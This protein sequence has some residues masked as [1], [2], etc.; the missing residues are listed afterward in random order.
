MSGRLTGSELAAAYLSARR[1]QPFGPSVR[2][3]V[4]RD[5]RTGIPGMCISDRSLCFRVSRMRLRSADL[6][7]C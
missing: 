5:T 3:I 6:L 7:I 4:V 2:L 1:R